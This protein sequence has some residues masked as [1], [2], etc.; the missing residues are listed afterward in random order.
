VILV[1]KSSAEPVTG[2]ADVAV[3]GDWRETL[4]A[5]ARTFAGSG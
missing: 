1:F 4:P 2:T 5:F 3:A